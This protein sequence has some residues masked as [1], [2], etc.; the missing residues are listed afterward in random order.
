MTT[1]LIGLIVNRYNLNNTQIEINI[2]AIKKK[3]FNKKYKNLY[4]VMCHATSGYEDINGV[5]DLLIL[6]GM[7]RIGII[8]KKTFEWLNVYLDLGYEEK[9][10]IICLTTGNAL[11]T[12]DV[13]ALHAKQTIKLLLRI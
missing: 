4:N 9:I 11:I 10:E 5:V 6:Q 8:F 2:K 12:S 3:A 7:C 13:M 1:K